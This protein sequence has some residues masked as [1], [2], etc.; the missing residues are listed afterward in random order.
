MSDKQKQ[1]PDRIRDKANAKR[2]LQ[3]FGPDHPAVRAAKRYCERTGKSWNV[4]IGG[5]CE[6]GKRAIKQWTYEATRPVR[7]AWQYAVAKWVTALV[8]SLVLVVI[9]LLTIPKVV[10][11]DEWL[12][13]RKALLAGCLKAALSFAP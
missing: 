13:A 1:L 4:G 11:R 3:T 9:G 2:G 12:V 10:S 8:I 6:L 7:K 5:R